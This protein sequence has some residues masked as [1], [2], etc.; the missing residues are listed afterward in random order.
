[1]T[2]PATQNE[3]EK[4]EML[5]T[6]L[7]AVRYALPEVVELLMGSSNELH[8]GNPQSKAQDFRH[9]VRNAERSFQDLQRSSSSLAGACGQEVDHAPSMIHAY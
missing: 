7:D 6:K 4:L 5:L 1:M 9:R 2:T 3:V 8:T